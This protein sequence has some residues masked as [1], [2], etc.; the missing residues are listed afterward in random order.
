MNEKADIPSTFYPVSFPSYADLTSRRWFT[1]VG[2]TIKL[3]PDS[4]GGL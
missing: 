1:G 3:N 2:D 4:D